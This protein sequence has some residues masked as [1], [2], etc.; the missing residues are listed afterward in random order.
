[1]FACAQ[2]QQQQ[3]QQQ[4]QEEEQEGG[5]WIAC[6]CMFAAAVRAAL[7]HLEA[8]L[9]R[10][11][12]TFVSLSSPHFGLIKGSSRLVAVGLWL[13]KKWRRSLCLQQL[14]LT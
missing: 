9:G 8:S 5:L 12:Y 6:V 4:Q 14:T 13:L 11:F 10:C 1:M 7:P 3:Q 2:P